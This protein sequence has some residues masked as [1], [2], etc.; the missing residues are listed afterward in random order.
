MDIKKEIE[1]LAKETEK[2]FKESIIT[3]ED[4]VQIQKIRVNFKDEV[5]EAMRTVYSETK[6][7]YILLER[8]YLLNIKK[9]RMGK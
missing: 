1:S 3:H 6:K 4:T 9:S 5:E 7:K 8:D 2:L